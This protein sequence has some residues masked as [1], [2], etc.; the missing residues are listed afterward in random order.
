MKEFWN[1]RFGMEE[2]VYGIEPNSF[3]KFELAKINEKGSALLPLEGEGRNAC[4]L[5]EKDWQ[6]DAFDFSE[7]GKEKAL[8]L[9]KSK[10]VSITYD[11]SKIEDYKFED[12]KYDL[13]VLIYAHLNP[14][15]RIKLHKNAIKSLKSGGKIILEAFHP[16]QLEGQYKSGNPKNKELLYDLASIKN[17]FN[18]LTESHGEELEIDL[19]E[20]NFHKGKAYVTRFTGVK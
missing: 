6:V 1:E 11:L 20:G 13:I 9:C 4:Y 17:D 12:G 16:Q 2:F 15:M 10:Q 5:A 3:L 19:T 18:E 7:A 8:K 14:E